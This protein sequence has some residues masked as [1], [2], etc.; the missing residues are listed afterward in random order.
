MSTLTDFLTGVADAI[1]AK[2][3]GSAPIPAESFPAE[4]AA[5]E[6]GTDTS[7]ATAAASDLL[8]GKTAYG[9]AGKLTG[10]IPSY[11]GP[12]TVAPAATAQTVVTGGTYVPSTIETAGDMYLVSSNIKAGV[13]IF[14]VTGNYG[15]A[16]EIQEYQEVLTF[17]GGT[18]NTIPVSYKDRNVEYIAFFYWT[19]VLEDLTEGYMV[20]GFCNVRAGSGGVGMCQVV[21]SGN[22]FGDTLYMDLSD[23]QNML[24]NLPFQPGR[25]DVLIGVRE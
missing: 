9:A 24:T 22:I 18:M 6:T 14:G 12:A 2:T 11:T 8:S 7:D 13:T 1:R 4:I 15:G 17:N 25:Y 5:I 19:G 10:T 20:S 16:G 23:G 21:G 3:G